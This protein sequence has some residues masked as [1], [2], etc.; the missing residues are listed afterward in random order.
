MRRTSTFIGGMAVGGLLIYAALSY[1]VLQTSDGLHLIAK[2][3]STLAATYVDIRGLGPVELLQ[4]H[5]QVAQAIFDSRRADLIESAAADT[6]RTG[7]DR[8]IGRL[9]ANP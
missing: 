3:E 2:R 6:I 4:R 9:P 5:P 8:A 1:H 7:I